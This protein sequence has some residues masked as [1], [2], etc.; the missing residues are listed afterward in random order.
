MVSGVWKQF[1]CVEVWLYRVV[2]VLRNN[3]R[4]S[5]HTGCSYLGFM[6]SVHAWG[7]Y[8]VFILGVHTRGSYLGF[9]LGVYT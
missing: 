2:A 4:F 9:I 1:W 7:L 5:V 6:L 3:L 8:L